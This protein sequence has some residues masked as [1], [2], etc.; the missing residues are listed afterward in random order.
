MATIPQDASHDIRTAFGQINDEMRSIKREN[1]SLRNHLSVRDGD[2]EKVR[3]DLER[4]LDAP[5]SL[6]FNDVFR[7]AGDAHS[8]G[9][10]VER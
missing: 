2:T 1:E 5:S 3:R 9:W 6:D 7:G 10:C 4:R 8:I